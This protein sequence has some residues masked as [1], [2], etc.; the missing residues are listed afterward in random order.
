MNVIDRKNRGAGIH[1]GFAAER[2]LAG[3]T[4]A[5]GACRAQY[6]DLLPRSGITP[7]VFRLQH[8]PQL[9]SEP[10]KSFVCRAPRRQKKVGLQIAY[11]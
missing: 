6:I 1:D 5:T 9:P 8:N 4:A 2:S 11:G 10:L 3:S 7:P